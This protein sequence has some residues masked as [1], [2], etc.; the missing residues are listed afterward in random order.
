M[1]LIL[2]DSNFKKQKVVK[3]PSFV[4]NVGLYGASKN[5]FE[6]TL[7]DD[8][9]LPNGG[10]LTYGTSEFGGVIAETVIDTAE[11][12]AKYIG[13][14][15]RG[16]M[17]NSIIAPFSVLTL[18]GTDFEIVSKLIEMSQ[19]DYTVNETNN[20]ESKSISFPVG[21]NLLKAVD[22]VLNSFGE[23]MLLKASNDG[24]RITLQEV[25]QKS[26]DASQVDLIIDDNKLLPT[27]LH[28]RKGSIQTSVYV[29]ADGSIG[30]TRY[31]TGF[32]AYEISEEITADSLSQMK[33][34]AADRLTA[35]RNTSNNSEVKVKIDDADIGDKINVSIKRIGKKS[36]QTV[37]EK[38]LNF[39]DNGEHIT[40]NT[41]G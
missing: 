39:A 22:I 12:T 40:F 3:N 7:T 28:A 8:D 35:L 41:G 37:C 21:S 13:K 33:S 4:C 29:Q 1:D 30:D 34:L 36:T 38:I 27:A 23:K 14:S 18:T 11:K 9:I 25:A 16:Q 2:R 5:D 20:T 32:E 19:L 24:V 15:F 17:E 26:F 31:Y 6:L 10:I